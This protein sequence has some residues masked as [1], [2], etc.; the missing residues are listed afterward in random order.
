MCQSEHGTVTK[1]PRVANVRQNYKTHFIL[2][3]SLHTPRF[4]EVFSC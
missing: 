4:R 1:L 2:A 3:G